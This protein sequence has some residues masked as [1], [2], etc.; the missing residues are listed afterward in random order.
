MLL[1]SLVALVAGLVPAVGRAQA[2]AGNSRGD[3]RAQPALAGSSRRQ[4]GQCAALALGALLGPTP[5]ALAGS[6]PANSYYFPMAKYRYLPRINRA[7][8]SLLDT[9]TQAIASA[10]WQATGA[11]F[12]NADDATTALKLYANSVEGSRSSKSKSKSLRQKQLY[13]YADEYVVAVEKLGKALGKQSSGAA[14]ATEAVAE[15]VAALE[16][17]KVLADITGANELPPDVPLDQRKYLA[18]FK[19]GGYADGNRAGA[20]VVIPLR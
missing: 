13:K 18:V 8:Y 14:C 5:E 7:Y 10:D 2:R 11:A 19:G 9:T 1:V 4:A 20:A 12:L 15:A 6:N 17:Y 3:S 16:K